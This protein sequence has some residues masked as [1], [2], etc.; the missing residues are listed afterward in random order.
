MFLSYEN[1]Y[2]IRTILNYFKKIKLWEDNRI[3]KINPKQID[4]SVLELA[5]SRY[6]IDSIKYFSDIGGGLLDEEL[7]I[8]QDSFELAKKALGGAIRAITCA[9][10]KECEQSIALIRPPGHHALR[11]RG[12]GLCI[13]NNIAN[14]ILYL[15]DVLQYDKRIAIV[16]IDDHFGDGIV[17]YFYDDPSVLYFSVHEYDFIEGDL[18]FINELGC[19]EGLGKSINFPFPPGIHDREFLEFM[20]VL[21]PVLKQFAPDLIIV[22]A[23]FDMY[24]DD[25]IGNCFLTSQSYYD[26]GTKI[27]ELAE[28]ICQGKLV[29]ILEGDYSLIG[30]NF[31][32]NKIIKS[33]LKEHFEK[34]FF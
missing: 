8:T 27:L 6:Y 15:R 10:E 22:A 33:L 26:F 23:G 32:I 7:Y 16:D 11:E 20:D 24:F 3:V 28:N 18:G 2:R 19:G 13:F 29:Y 21:E 17:Q 4:E 12:S 31:C 1:P 34:L 25:T 14:S 5:H 9:L 30:L